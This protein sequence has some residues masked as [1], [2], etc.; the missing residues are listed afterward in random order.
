MH[1]RVRKQARGDEAKAL[2]FLRRAEIGK[3]CVGCSL[4]AADGTKDGGK[5]KTP[6]LRRHLEGTVGDVM[7]K[8]ELSGG[9]KA[10][11]GAESHGLPDEIVDTTIAMTPV[12]V[13]RCSDVGESQ[14]V[15]GIVH[16][17]P[18][19]T[20]LVDRTCEDVDGVTGLDQMRC[21]VPSVTG[22]GSIVREAGKGG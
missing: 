3:Q 13:A 14:I 7:D 9:C 15:E 8:I 2:L 20:L 19:D 21:P 6:E 17:I 11:R 5:S 12:F 1:G 10:A 22:F 16:K 18:F 4:A